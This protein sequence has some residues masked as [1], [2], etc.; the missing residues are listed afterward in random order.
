MRAFFLGAATLVRVHAHVPTAGINNRTLGDLFR[1]ALEVFLQLSVHHGWR[2]L[3]IVMFRL[4][5]E[6]YAEGS[7]PAVLSIRRA[8]LAFQ[9]LRQ[10][11]GFL[12]ALFAYPCGS[13][14]GPAD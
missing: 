2:G 12:A 11:R 9:G 13:H 8:S 4:G 10:E 7:P 5:A 6:Q 3:Q 1:H 14:A